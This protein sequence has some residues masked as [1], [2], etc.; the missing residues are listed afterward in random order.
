MNE[1]RCADVINCIETSCKLN[2]FN[3]IEFQ[4]AAFSYASNHK[5]DC[6]DENTGV[7]GQ[8][9]NVLLTALCMYVCVGMCLF[10]FSEVNR[11]Y[12]FSLLLCMLWSQV[13]GVDPV[14]LDSEK[15]LGHLP[16]VVSA[17]KKLLKFF[18]ASE[19]FFSSD[20]QATNMVWS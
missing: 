2:F 7:E 20:I 19:T 12:S 16:G 6:M 17:E 18:S 1:N 8:C 13:S 10:V 5:P 14:F 11:E 9:E 3:Q 4:T 15:S